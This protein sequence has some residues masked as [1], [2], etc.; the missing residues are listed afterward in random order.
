MS[1]YVEVGYVIVLGSL[2][3]YAV[4]LV[5]RERAARRRLPKPVSDRT[6]TDDAAGAGIAS[7]DRP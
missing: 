4:S 1:G 6:E 5:T 7:G 2:G 3:S